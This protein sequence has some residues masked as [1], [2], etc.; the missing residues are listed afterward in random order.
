MHGR[1]LLLAHAVEVIS[2]ATTS[3]EY[4]SPSGYE[5]IISNV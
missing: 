5:R 2:R 3:S 1:F 4:M